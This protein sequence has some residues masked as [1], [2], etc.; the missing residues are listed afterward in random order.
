[1]Y[2]S[3]IFPPLPTIK[4]ADVSVKNTAR[5]TDPTNSTI[6]GI[7]GYAYLPNASEPG[8]LKVHFDQGSPKDADY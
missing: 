7:T 2:Y 1:M 5:L 3:T 6:A 8:K 4:S